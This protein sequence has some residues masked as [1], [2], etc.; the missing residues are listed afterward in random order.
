MNKELILSAIANTDD[1]GIVW[2]WNGMCRKT[3]RTEDIVHDC[4]EETFKD[5]FGSIEKALRAAWLGHYDYRDRFFVFDG[6]GM[7]TFYRM[8][9]KR[10][11]IDTGELAEWLSENPDSMAMRYLGGGPED[12]PETFETEEDE[13][14]SIA[15]GLGLCKPWSPS[16]KEGREQHGR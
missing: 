15:R 3:G 10:S 1:H 4:D 12:E 14:M 8:S 5:V 9:D 13:E 11:P 2:A 7:D 16:E 6:D